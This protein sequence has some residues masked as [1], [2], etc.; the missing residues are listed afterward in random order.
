[1]SLII[2][3]QGLNDAQMELALLALPAKKRQ[4]ALWRIADGIR[5][6]SKRNDKA[7][8]DPEGKPWTPRKHQRKRGNKTKMFRYLPNG[9]KV[10]DTPEYAEVYF[11]RATKGNSNF[12]AGVI[13]NMHQTGT[14]VHIN[15]SNFKRKMR[16]YEQ[17]KGLD[18]SAAT[19][20]QARFLVKLGMKRR[21][22]KR[23]V[24]ATSSWIQQNISYQQAGLLIS[25][26]QNDTAAGKSSWDVKLPKR[27]L[28][29]ISQ[30]EGRKIFRRV[31]QGINYGW[32]VKKQDMR[33]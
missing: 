30:Q 14:S 13:A 22:K 20:K 5:Q 26:L 23:W 33:G 31:M 11:A 17:R 25:K 24:R 27:G 3:P 21:N 2:T 7:Q 32:N 4:R 6:N 12:S 16:E 18:K 28:L 19:V 8:Q 9:M 29:G 1:M 10:K 15:G